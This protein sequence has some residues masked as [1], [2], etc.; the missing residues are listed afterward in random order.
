MSRKRSTFAEQMDFTTPIGS[1]GLTAT[2]VEAHGPA[3]IG[4]SSADIPYELG[5]PQTATVPGRHT[6]TKVLACNSRVNRQVASAAG[7]RRS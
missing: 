6:A 7:A 5:L 3:Q 1:P 4:K 2:Q